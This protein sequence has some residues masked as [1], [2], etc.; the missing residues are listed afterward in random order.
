MNDTQ[1]VNINHEL[2]NPI[3]YNHKKGLM[4]S[5]VHE[6]IDWRFAN[7]FR[8]L[9]YVRDPNIINV[10]DDRDK[11]TAED[12]SPFSFWLGISVF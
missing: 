5:Q 3:E 4:N 12:W 7:I 2:K 6:K 11:E 1:K 9:S 10:G 8:R